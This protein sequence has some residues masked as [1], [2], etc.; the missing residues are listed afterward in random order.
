M[1]RRPRPVSAPTKAKLIINLE[2]GEC[3]F[4]TGEDEEGRFLFCSAETNGSSWCES[5]SDRV[6][7]RGVTGG[8]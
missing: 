5:H 8:W 6:F 7:K 4:S 3:K 1:K 2:P